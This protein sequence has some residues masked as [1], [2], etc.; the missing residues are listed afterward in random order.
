MEKYINIVPVLSRR[1]LNIYQKGIYSG[2]KTK[3]KN[4]TNKETQQQKTIQQVKQVINK[5][6]KN[7]FI[8]RKEKH[9]LLFE[10]QQ[11][12]NKIRN[13]EDM[14]KSNKDKELRQEIKSLLVLLRNRNKTIFVTLRKLEK[15]IIGFIYAIKGFESEIVNLELRKQEDNKPKHN[16]KTQQK[17][18]TPLFSKL[19]S[20]YRYIVKSPIESNNYKII[21]TLTQEQLQKVYTNLKGK[22]K[23]IDRKKL[24]K[25]FS[26]TETK[27]IQVFEKSNKN[28]KRNENI[29]ALLKKQGFQETE[30]QN[31]FIDFYNNNNIKHKNN[32]IKSLIDK[33]FSCVDLSTNKINK[34]K[35]AL[36]FSVMLEGQKNII[37]PQ[38]DFIAKYYKDGWKEKPQNK[39]FWSCQST[40]VQN[41]YLREIEQ[42]NRYYSIME[43][44]INRGL[45]N[46]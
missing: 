17:K 13:Y 11:N 3:M 44:R 1:V 5:Y 15:Y 39:S 42:K 20:F 28:H 12:N 35:L 18:T 33:F 10:L 19:L 43:S 37:V 46:E 40:K 7:L 23:H 26:K 4:T 21:P 9:N 25:E 34:R 45:Q 36:I 22:Y 27:N 2:E 14:Y 29:K 16:T 24:L 38:I 8:V 41:E 31:L 6:T 32:K 30:Q